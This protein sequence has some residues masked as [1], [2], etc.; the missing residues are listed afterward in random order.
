MQGRGNQRS[1]RRITQS[2]GKN[3]VLAKLDQIEAESRRRGV[4]AIVLIR[5]V[6]QEWQIYEAIPR[7]LIDSALD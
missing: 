7:G 6:D 5:M 4:P 2:R 3:A 1:R